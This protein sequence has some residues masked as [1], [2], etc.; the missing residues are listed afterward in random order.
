MQVQ[1]QSMQTNMKYMMHSMK[2]TLYSIIPI[3]VI[4]SWMNANFAFEP[5]VPGQEFTTTVIVGK[6]FDDQI[7][8]SVPYG[9]TISGDVI[10]EV[11]DSEVKWILSGEEGEYLLEYIINGNKYNKEVLITEENRYRD[12]IKKVNDGVVKSIE[13][14]HKEKKLI[15]L[16]GW[17]IGW[18]GTYIIFSII[19]SILV[20]KIIKVY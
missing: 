18:L 19:F 13:I 2:S 8:L 15:N 12:P 4:F 17:K 20:R 1:K 6:N 11:K 5:I 7:E 3:I 10:K 9:I 16:F 14:D